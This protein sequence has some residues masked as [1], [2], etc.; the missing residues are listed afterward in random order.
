M[1]GRVR[2]GSGGRGWCAAGLIGRHAQLA[3]HRVLVTD[4][5]IETNRSLRLK[6]TRP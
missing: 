5:V 2:P 3:V 6:V 4:L 1:P